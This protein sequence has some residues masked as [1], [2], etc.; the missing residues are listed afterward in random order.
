MSKPVTIQQLLNEIPSENIRFQLVG[1]SLME[2]DRGSSKRPPSI[3]IGVEEDVAMNFMRFDSTNSD[4]GMLIMIKRDDFEK[5][6][7]NLG[8]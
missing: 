7:E 1:N 8:L 3:R 5:A 4:V 6:K 2:A